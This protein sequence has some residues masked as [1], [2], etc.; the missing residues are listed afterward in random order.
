V[1]GTPAM[2]A[3]GEMSA[4]RRI[5]CFTCKTHHDAAETM[6]LKIVASGNE[7]N[8]GSYESHLANPMCYER[9]RRGR[10]LGSGWGDVAGGEKERGND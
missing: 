8:L 3:V 9:T 7:N 2:K 6:Y 10:G 5:K 1:F 4:I